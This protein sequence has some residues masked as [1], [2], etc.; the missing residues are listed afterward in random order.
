MVEVFGGI[1]WLNII[2]LKNSF[3][4]DASRPCNPGEAPA[5]AV[6]AMTTVPAG[7]RRCLEFSLAWDMPIV[8]FGSKKMKHYR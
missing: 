2:L 1:I 7:E 5:A 3:Y 4:Q 6:A 8:Y